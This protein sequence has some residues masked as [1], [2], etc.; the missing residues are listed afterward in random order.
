MTDTLFSETSKSPGSELSQGMC[1]Q[2]YINKGVLLKVYLCAKLLQF[3][4]CS[5]YGIFAE[6]YT[7]VFGSLELLPHMGPSSQRAI[8]FTWHLWMAER[9]EM[10]ID[11]FH[12][13]FISPIFLL[14]QYLNSRALT[15]R[16]HSIKKQKCRNYAELWFSLGNNLEYSNANH[17]QCIFPNNPNYEVKSKAHSNREKLWIRIQVLEHRSFQRCNNIQHILWDD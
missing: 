1:T 15:G 12:S 16:K 11:L 14:K 13:D 17:Y 4:F 6:L 8:V 2:A 9:N 5:C 7:A 10:K 3:F